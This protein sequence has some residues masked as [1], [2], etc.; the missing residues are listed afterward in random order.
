MISII[1]YVT[2][3]QS[4]KLPSCLILCLN[5]ATFLILMFVSLSLVFAIVA[6]EVQKTDL[7]LYVHTWLVSTL[8]VS[9]RAQRIKQ[10]NIQLLLMTN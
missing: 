5:V 1:I 4:V 8:V 7:K 2:N 3:L 10:V 9:L 6:T